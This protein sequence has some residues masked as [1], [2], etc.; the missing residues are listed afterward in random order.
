MLDAVQSGAPWFVGI[1]GEPGIGK[2][3]LLSELGRRAE[4]RGW[5]VLD[6]RAAEFERDVP[7]GLIVDALNDY[8]GG[9]EPALLRS[10][11]DD[12]LAELTSIFPSFSSRGGRL[13]AQRAGMER[14]R[15]HYAIRALLERL[16]ARDALV[17]ALDDV[18]WADAA[19]IEVIGH[20]A[21]RFRGPLLLAVAARRPPG[22]LDASLVAA[23]RAGFGSRLQLAPLSSDD[24]AVLLGPDVDVVARATLYR[25]SGGNPF[26]LEQLARSSPGRGPPA[27][28][29]TERP[30]VGW[31]PPAVVVAAIRGEV[32]ELSAEARGALNAAAVAGE[33]FEAELLAAIADRPHAPTMLAVDELVVADL[34][35]PTEAPTRFRFRHPI[36]RTVVYDAMAPGLA[37]GG[38]CA[39]G[40]GARSQ[41]RAGRSVRA[42]CRAIGRRWRR[43]RDRAARRRRAD[44][45]LAGAVDGGSLAACRVAVAPSAR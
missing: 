35:R 18:H 19:S 44:R 21:R 17:L 40:R 11:D 39:G 15:V 34:I 2:T 41:S 23:Q 38:A 14:Y 24:A 26:Y 20:L 13:A 30:N 4:E 1:V 32:A 25:E 16:A 3:R 9:L 43:A 8:L 5:L 36:V 6:G 12:A 27:S 28:V 45:R 10:L 29:L 37:A 42:S 22:R 31:A 33:S 7:F